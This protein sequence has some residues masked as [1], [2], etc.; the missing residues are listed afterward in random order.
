MKSNFVSH[1]LFIS[2]LGLSFFF[3]TETLAS[4]NLYVCR[5]TD[6]ASGRFLT[7]G[8]VDLGYR[9]SSD[10]QYKGDIVNFSAA[11]DG[12]VIRV[13]FYNRRDGRSEVSQMPIK[14]NGS[15]HNKSVVTFDF[16]MGLK[17]TCR[18]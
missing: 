3:S 10:F 14:D 16:A 15:E 7:R 18:R 5:V 9:V 8:T 13:S 6:A 12:I 1:L 4:E 11:T 2:Y 17:T